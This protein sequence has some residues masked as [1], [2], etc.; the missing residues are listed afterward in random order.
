[1]AIHSVSSEPESP[2]LEKVV[3]IPP[4]GRLEKRVRTRRTLFSGYPII[5]HS[6]ILSNSQ[7]DV[8]NKLYASGSPSAW[9][10]LLTASASSLPSIS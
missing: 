8:L 9:A 5:D 6:I 1:M 10:I 2:F 3:L 7:N 4:P